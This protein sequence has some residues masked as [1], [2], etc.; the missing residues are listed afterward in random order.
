MEYI[1][2]KDKSGK[3]LVIR[4]ISTLES[5]LSEITRLTAQLEVQ[6]RTIRQMRLEIDALHAKY[7]LDVIGHQVAAE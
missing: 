6:A 2:T 3:P 7:G 5:A 4:K 1:R